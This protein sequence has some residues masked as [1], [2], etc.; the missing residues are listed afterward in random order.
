MC[1]ICINGFV[2]NKIASILKTSKLLDFSS[3]LRPKQFRH[4]SL[5]WNTRVSNE[6]EAFSCDRSVQKTSEEN[7]FSLNQHIF[8]VLSVTSGNAVRWGGPDQHNADYSH[9]L[10]R[11]P[12]QAW[13][14]LLE[15]SVSFINTSDPLEGLFSSRLRE[16]FRLCATCTT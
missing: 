1:K 8:N 15:S 13:K 3:A 4:Y 10:K 9:L 16:I 6:A 14:E 5:Y 2:F 7:G 12:V 11:S